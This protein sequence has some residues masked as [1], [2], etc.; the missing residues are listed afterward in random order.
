[1]SE[2]SRFF[3]IIIRMRFEPRARHH[4]PHFHVFYQGY[5]AAYGISPI[6]LLAGEL[7][8]RQRRLVEAWA[9]LHQEE[10]QAAWETLQ[11]GR[12]PEKIVPLQ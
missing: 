1:M 3:G 11:L 4:T 8:R 5:L 10:L 6:E 7:P 9:E 12:A 2:L